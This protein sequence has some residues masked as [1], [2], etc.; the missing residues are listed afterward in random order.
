MQGNP[1]LLITSFPHHKCHPIDPANQPDNRR[2]G[3]PHPPHQ[4]IANKTT[5]SPTVPADDAMALC[6]E[7][8]RH[9][10]SIYL[11]TVYAARAISIDSGRR[12]VA[13]MTMIERSTIERSKVER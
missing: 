11:F 10:L 13:E 9:T 4:K 8:R 12:A 1:T 5:P 6:S 3:T 7:N 2:P